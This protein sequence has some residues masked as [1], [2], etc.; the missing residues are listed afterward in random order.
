ML[1]IHTHTNTKRERETELLN[2]TE[3]KEIGI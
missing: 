2:E 3:R 1:Y